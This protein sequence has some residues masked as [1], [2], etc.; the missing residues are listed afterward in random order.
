[1]PKSIELLSSSGFSE[2]PVVHPSTDDNYLLDD[3][4]RTVTSVAER[5]SRSVVKIDVEQQ[6]GPS[7]AV[8]SGSGSGVVFTP[9]GFIITNSHVVHRAS[10]I[11]VKTVD[12]EAFLGHLGGGG[13]DTDLALVPICAHQVV[14]VNTAKFIAG[15]LII[16]RFIR[17]SYI[18]LQAQTAPLNRTIAKFHGVENKTGALALTIEPKSP[19]ERAGMR[20]GDVIVRF[21]GEEIL[22]VDGLHKILNEERTGSA[23]PVVVPRRNNN[24]GLVAHPDPQ[25]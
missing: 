15:R 11:Q 21:G 18:G 20:E 6:R 1:M 7:A 25:Q 5:V 17:R 13:P 2:H 24:L 22:G 8:Q 23:T 16:D 12:G 4:S 14:S 10:K 9:D 19:A 3:Y